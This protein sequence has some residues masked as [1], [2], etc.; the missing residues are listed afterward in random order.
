MSV[1]ESFILN[2]G[3]KYVQSRR[4]ICG[5]RLPY[6]GLLC[7]AGRMQQ[8]MHYTAQLP[9]RAEILKVDLYTQE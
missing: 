2:C 6:V 5:R 8:D 7:G 4:T 9:F 1:H 3:Y